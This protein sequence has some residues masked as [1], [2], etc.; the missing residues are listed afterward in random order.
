MDQ[1]DDADAGLPGQPL[2]GGNLSGVV[3][4]GAL[5]ERATGPWSP[6]VHAL[7]RHLAARGF[8]GAPRVHGVAAGR[9][10]LSFIE[11]AADD[12]ALLTDDRALEQL[13]R[14]IRRLHDAAA[15]FV[16]PDAAAWQVVGP[17]P[18]EVICHN[19][20]APYNIVCRDGMP[21]ALIDFD[22][23]GP[24]PRAWDIAYALYR[25]VPLD[26]REAARVGCALPAAARRIACFCAAYGS[27]ADEPLLQLVELRL[28]A[29]CLHLIRQ[30]CA[31]VPAYRQMLADGHL[32][33][34]QRALATLRRRRAPLA[35][36]LAA[37][38][39]PPAS[40]EPAADV[41]PS[42]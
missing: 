4:R 36:L 35:A 19:D 39:P 21:Q 10:L 2:P 11:G 32:L 30:A 1:P 24:G 7:L 40:E 20:I 41:P 37:G 22:V 33:E 13:A 31:G 8:A 5:V 17:P 26:P 12:D 34:Y 6:A 42:A 25:C 29:L 14:L 23:A 16:A 15:D 9:E 3:R 28:H 18:H 38:A 27:A